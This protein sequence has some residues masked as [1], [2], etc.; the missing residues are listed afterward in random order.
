MTSARLVFFRIGVAILAALLVFS[1]CSSIRPLPLHSQNILSDDSNSEIKITPSD[2]SGQA[3][4][5]GLV[6]TD[7]SHVAM[8]NS[9][10]KEVG[11]VKREDILLHSLNFDMD[12]KPR[13][14]GDLFENS[15]SSE[16]ENSG[17]NYSYNNQID[18]IFD[19]MREYFSQTNDTK[20]PRRILIFV[21]GGLNTWGEALERVV[22]PVS[23]SN[24]NNKEIKP[25]FEVI[26]RE[27]WEAEEGYYPIFI[28]WETS[29]WSSYGDHLF[30][31]RQGKETRPLYGKISA[32]VILGTDIA[33]GIFRAPLVWTSMFINSLV[34][35][36]DKKENRLTDHEIADIE[37]SHLECLLNQ[38]NDLCKEC[39]EARLANETLPACRG[40]PEPIN[41]PDHIVPRVFNVDRV[42]PRHEAT[43]INKK[44]ESSEQVKDE[45]DVSFGEDKSTRL[46]DL[47]DTAFANYLLP[48]KM[49]TSPIID[50][51]G[52]SA[53]NNM[54]RRTYL[55][56]HDDGEYD[57][58]KN[59]GSPR[60]KSEAVTSVCERAK[61]EKPGGG[62]GLFLARLN[63]EIRK[64][65]VLFAKNIVREL[66]NKTTIETIKV[67]V[68]AVKTAAEKNESNRKEIR[69]SL[70]KIRDAAEKQIQGKI[71]LEDLKSKTAK[72]QDI[73]LE[74]AREKGDG[75]LSKALNDLSEQLRA[76]CKTNNESHCGFFN[77]QAG[78]IETYLRQRNRPLEIT[79]VGHSMGTIVL[80]EVIRRNPYLPIKNIVYMA[81]AST[82][83]DYESSV[84]PYL[85]KNDETSFYNLMLHPKAEREERPAGLE[86]VPRGSLL[87]W[88]DDFLS[89]PLTIYDRT[90]GRFDNY[91]QY[92]HHVP[93]KPNDLK[94]RIYVRSFS[95]GEC[96]KGTDPQEHGNFSSN[97]RF[98]EK[99]CWRNLHE[100]GCYD[101]NLMKGKPEQ[102]SNEKC[103][104]EESSAK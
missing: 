23:P 73:L 87:V 92:T 24:G 45:I 50:A 1:G 36:L 63:C 28:N 42:S 59:D 32:P 49:I 90:L 82:I 58:K 30:S 83:R 4:S 12:G 88:I 7:P 69:N 27:G 33:R 25:L 6:K 98:W 13:D 35:K 2:S 29:L 48:I 104:N 81:A 19:H 31:I 60:N 68:D 20:K 11:T 71:D 46:E 64:A 34:P 54:L 21:H 102:P 70:F 52:T 80:N 101:L 84:I 93:T 74:E 26:K 100:K 66:N 96:K 65:D 86:I 16:S 91:L 47:K 78:H 8:L 40:F 44:P 39:R 43:G 99:R 15:T 56:F 103:I 38:K 67:K 95:A 76:A 89:N 79:L 17:D 22:R 85:R 77:K 75:K 94:K 61:T 37:A 57:Y 41:P 62:L 10:G 5:S 14:P 3:A 9:E 55:L 72:L 97:Y 53:W 18:K 51:F